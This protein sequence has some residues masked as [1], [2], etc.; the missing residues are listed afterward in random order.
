MWCPSPPSKSATMP[1]LQGFFLESF[2]RFH[3]E[4]LYPSLY[5]RNT[6]VADGAIADAG[7][8]PAGYTGRYLWIPSLMAWRG[9]DSTWCSLPSAFWGLPSAVNRRVAQSA[10]GP[11]LA[12]GAVGP[13]L[14][15]WRLGSIAKCDHSARPKNDIEPPAAGLRQNR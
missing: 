12:V 14:G 8:Q 4:P 6:R 11:R 7:S 15:G 3:G 5:Q 2:R 9:W 10:S 1:S 13:V